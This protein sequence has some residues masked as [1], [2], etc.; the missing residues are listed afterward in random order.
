MTPRLDFGYLYDFRNPRHSERPWSDVYAENLDV[1]AW[2][3]T[4]GFS[5]AWVPEHHNASDGYQPAPMVAL[6]AIAARTDTLRL[7][8]AVSLGPLYHPVRFAEECAV[9]DILS[10]GR[11]EMSLAIGYRRSEYDA[12]GLDFKTRGK[13]FDEFLHIVRALWAGET[14]NFEGRHFTVK[15]AK[16]MPPSP[17]GQVPLYI[18]GFADKALERV[19]KYAD[20]YFGNEEFCDS[21]VAKLQAQGKDPAE[22]G[23][24]IQGLFYVVAEDPEKAMEELAPYYHHVNNSYGEWLNEDNAIGFDNAALKPMSLEDFKTSGILEIATPDKAISK[25]KDL[26]ERTKAEHFMMMMPAGL[27]SD[28]F[29]EYAQVFAD[30]VIPAFR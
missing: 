4:V 24:R 3:E 1:I 15:N 28:R 29:M 8:S 22:A 20:G 19:A 16:I 7:G 23:I 5:G 25:F 2:S 30:K 6:A 11:A 18:G 27:P 17:R 14:V 26:Q 12:F 21:Y 10:R 13:R 9:L